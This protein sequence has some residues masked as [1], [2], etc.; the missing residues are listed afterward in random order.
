MIVIKAYN[1]FI[2]IKVY[3][4]FILLNNKKQESY[5]IIFQIIKDIITENNTLN[6]KLIS[7]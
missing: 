7:I 3:S 2:G 6:L 1:A 5:E 4:S